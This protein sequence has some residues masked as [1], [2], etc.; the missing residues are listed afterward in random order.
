MFSSTLSQIRCPK[1]KKKQQA[2]GGGKPNK[3]LTCAGKLK[4]RTAKTA[5]TAETV[6]LTV[7]LDV[8]AKPADEKASGAFSDA[9]A[10]ISQ[11]TKTEIITGDLQCTQCG[12]I[13]PILA[14][15]AIL[16]DDV[17]DYLL[18]H[19]KGISKLVGDQEIPSQYRSEFQ[20]IRAELN[21]NPEHIEEDLEADRVNALYVMTHYLKA[22]PSELGTAAPRV[23]TSLAKATAIALPAAAAAAAV[24][25]ADRKT[26]N[27]VLRGN[28][29][30]NPGTGNSTANPGTGNSVAHQGK[31]N[32]VTTKTP[33]QTDDP[34]TD[35]LLDTQAHQSPQSRQSGST[36]WWKPLEGEGSS[37]IAEL[38]EKYWNTGPS[39][40][41]KNWI[42]A[43]TSHPEFRALELGCGVGGFLALMHTSFQSYLGIDSSFASIA[44]ARHLALGL[45]YKGSLKIPEDLINGGLSRAV[46]I[47]PLGPTAKNF[48]FVVGD[49]ELPPVDS[50]SQFNLCVSL[51]AIDML[52]DPAL[53][54]E[55]QYGLLEP[56]GIAI[57]S[58]P[59]VWHSLAVK[60]L[61][62]KIA[63]TIRTSSGAVQALYS[64]QGFRH[65]HSVEHVPWLFFK[66]VRQLEI[67]SVHIL[68]TQK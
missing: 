20:A 66:H 64:N 25:D 59:Y 7:S 14:G 57:Q 10:E 40:Q 54:P 41:I 31:P 65:L 68:V 49:I 19:V 58:S 26:Q 12:A 5:K 29:F 60:K 43:R 56:N 47:T 38:I 55:L 45:T 52:T 42:D 44:L 1:K 8:E 11:R 4:I 24:I 22:N 37:L 27:K 21:A 16:V 50:T 36:P 9:P 13:Y 18:N 15:V 35:R 51:N 53:L 30:A 39:Y 63:Q 32:S 48:D 23:S 34:R 28:D 62:K 46:S 33:D 17:R 67:Y 6:L 2:I 61:R 3:A